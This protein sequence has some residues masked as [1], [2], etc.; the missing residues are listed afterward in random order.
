MAKIQG[1]GGGT[2]PYRMRMSPGRRPP[3]TV[4]KQ[5]HYDDLPEPEDERALLGL[6]LYREAMEFENIAYQVLGFTKV[7]NV[8][9]AQAA[10]QIEWIKMRS[11]SRF[12]I[13]PALPSAFAMRPLT[14]P[15][16]PWT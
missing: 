14:T 10:S 2:F 3:G 1:S 16:P 6:A 7:F 5:P 9:Y 15:L 4:D 13:S 11:V 12:R 8:L